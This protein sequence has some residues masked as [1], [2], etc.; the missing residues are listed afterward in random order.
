MA[1]VA[2]GEH[3]YVKDPLDPPVDGQPGGVIDLRHFTVTAR[4]PL[5]LGEWAGAAEEIRQATKDQP[6]A[7]L[8]EDYKS[9]FLG[10]VFRNN[11]WQNDGDIS[12]ELQEF[13]KDYE[14]G[15]LRGFWPAVDRLSET[16]AEKGQAG[17]R[18]LRE[19]QDLLEDRLARG[20][21]RFQDAPEGILNRLE[22]ITERLQDIPGEIRDRFQDGFRRL[23]DRFSLGQEGSSVAR[24]SSSEQATEAQA[25][26]GIPGNAFRLA[27]ARVQEMQGPLN[28]GEEVLAVAER[29]LGNGLSPGDLID[30]LG[31][32]PQ[33]TLEQVAGPL[34]EIF[35]NAGV[36]L[37][38]GP[39]APAQDALEA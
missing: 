4:V 24:E 15:N 20:L 10:T 11:Y 5:G 9:N 34:R 33:S 22:G 37:A 29:L 30:V 35:Q 13:F 18:E 7:H 39:Q 31:Q 17:L 12:D 16:A 1:R 27:A 26:S 25:G 19:L 28:P 36:E 6:S 21:E 38:E 3:R 2:N 32:V 8:D 14:E 23:R